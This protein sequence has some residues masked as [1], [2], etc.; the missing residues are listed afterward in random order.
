MPVDW[1]ALRC[2]LGEDYEVGTWFCV[3]ED[4]VRMRRGRQFA[5]KHGMRRVVQAT[6]P[7]PNAVLYPRSTSIPG[8]FSHPRHVHPEWEGKCEIDRDG[9][10]QLNVPVTV[11]T[12]ALCH[13]S[14]CCCEPDGTGLLEAIR[15]AAAI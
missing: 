2:A 12:D 15:G 10:V 3:P 5:N 7:G 8:P 11:C 14:Y 9:W 4:L 6:R 1:D 13:D